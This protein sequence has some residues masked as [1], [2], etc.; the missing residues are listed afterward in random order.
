[1]RNTALVGFLSL[2]L[3]FFVSGC[4]S[5]GDNATKNHG[6]SIT[7][8]TP[9]M[10]PSLNSG[11]DAN[12]QIKGDG[13]A[14]GEEVSQPNLQITNQNPQA[15]PLLEPYLIDLN[16]ML[17]GFDELNVLIDETFEKYL[18]YP[19][20]SKSFSDY[21]KALGN[22]VEHLR[23]V[24]N[25][26]PPENLN[27]LHQDFVVASLDLGNSYEK[28]ADLM[29][30]GFSAETQEELEEFEDLT[31]EIVGVT[32]KFVSTAFALMVVMDRPDLAG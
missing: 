10:V 17:D 4:S 6:S 20:S 5:E 18:E 8:E 16:D 19:D 11:N 30:E 9:G 14:S 3:L 31:A 7:T 32:E 2:T 27:I 22:L 26:T 24:E 28:V 1:M 12:N 29:D 25:L 13:T 21:T 15:D 23:S